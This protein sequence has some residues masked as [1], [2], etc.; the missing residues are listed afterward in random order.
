MTEALIPLFEGHN[1]RVLEKD[2][3][4]WF[5]LKDLADAWGLRPN[6]LY[7]IIA[8]NEKK[9][10]NRVSDVH[11]TCTPPEPESW[12]KSVNEQGLYVL[13][14]A[15]NTDR[16]KNPQAADAIDRFQYWVPELIQ[17]YRK[18][19]IVQ[20][21][22]A[23]DIRAELQEA[24]ELAVICGKS[25]ESFQAVI[26]RKHGKTELADA[27]TPSLVHGESGWY[28]PTRLIETFM[29]H[30]PTLTPKRLNQYLSNTRE[31]GMWAPFQY[32]DENHIWRLAP[33]GIPHGKE[34]EY[35]VPDTG[36]KEI[37]IQWKESVLVAAGLKRPELQEA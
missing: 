35:T 8:R 25:P 32:R 29:R 15:V 13:I 30:D 28:T 34:K 2:G 31:N 26:L 36:H 1:I 7:Q 18:R 9:F 27:L 6:T 12:H 37:R 11:V 23:P 14:G 20:V 33:R 22:V 4:P 16:L 21:P 10:K 24:R 5:P 17:K 19:E 3:E